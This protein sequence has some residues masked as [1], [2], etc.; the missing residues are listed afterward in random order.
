MGHEERVSVTD[1]GPGPLLTPRVLV[2]TTSLVSP[3]TRGRAG[4]LHE[5][6]ELSVRNVPIPGIQLT[7]D[8]VSVQGAA[9]ILLPPRAQLRLVLNRPCLAVRPREPR[10]YLVILTESRITRRWSE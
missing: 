5:V 8:E 4:H 9:S 3:A 2:Y 7:D 1:P 10:L 6:E